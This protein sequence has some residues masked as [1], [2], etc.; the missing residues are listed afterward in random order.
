MSFPCRTF[1]QTSNPHQPLFFNF[2]GHGGQ[3]VSYQKSQVYAVTNLNDGGPGSLA[4][5]PANSYIIF[6][7]LSG[8]ILAN[9]SALTTPGWWVLGQTSPAG[10]QVRSATNPSTHGLS[11]YY[12]QANDHIWQHLRFR[13]SAPTGGTGGAHSSLVVLNSNG[14]VIDHM[15]I[16]F[17]EDDAFDT[18]GTSNLSVLNSLI[19]EATDGQT[20]A[21]NTLI[22]S[23]G[24]NITIAKNV[25][26]LGDARGPRVGDA[27][28]VDVCNNYS[29][30]MVRAIS[31][32][33]LNTTTTANVTDN[34]IQ[35]TAF[36]STFWRDIETLNNGSPILVYESGNVVSPTGF[37][38]CPTQPARFYDG[39]TGADSSPGHFVN[40]PYVCPPVSK[41][42]VCDLEGF[43]LEGVGASHNRDSHDAGIINNIRNRVDAPIQP[44][45]EA[46]G[47]WPS[48]VGGN[49]KNPWDPNAPDYLSDAI[50]IEC[51]IPAGTNTTQTSINGGNRN[52][53]L[54][55]I[56]YCFGI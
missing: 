53:F 29:Y 5:A 36:S 48:M 20:F 38:G 11:P 37:T 27:T 19:G 17:G 43:L 50:K 56:N 55:I 45:P 41:V 51:G 16:Q 14:V 39:G 1:A 15:S 54:Y 6:P 47:G 52:D 49:S 31:I 2:E 3:A 21:P 8:D 46:Y 9:G 26:Y 32:H 34:V 44:T 30:G 13:A 12:I 40:T 22:G 28:F 35:R 42:N 23:G 10:I 4:A 24:S 33:G 25:F 7:N 18:S